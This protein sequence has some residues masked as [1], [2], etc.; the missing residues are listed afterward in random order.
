MAVAGDR[1]EGG[2]G[3]GEEEGGPCAGEGDED[4]VAYADV[5]AVWLGVDDAS[6]PATSNSGLPSLQQ[7]S[8]EVPGQQYLLPLQPVTIC[9]PPGF[10]EMMGFN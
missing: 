8:S 3:E 6:A 4:A 2:G 7:S 5:F 9:H 1:D 10:A